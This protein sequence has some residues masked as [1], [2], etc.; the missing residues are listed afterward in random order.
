MNYLDIKNTLDNLWDKIGYEELIKGLMSFEL[1]EKDENILNQ[2]YEYY[3]AYSECS[4]LNDILVD[5]YNE[6]KGGEEDEKVYY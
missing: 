3:Y 6:L 4:L 2:L 5:K 1:D